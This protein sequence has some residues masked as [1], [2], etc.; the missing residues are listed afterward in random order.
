MT[1][2]DIEETTAKPFPRVQRAKGVHHTCGPH[3]PSATRT[4]SS[5]LSNERSAIEGHL[6]AWCRRSSG[7]APPEALVVV[8]DLR[9]DFGRRL[10]LYLF[11]R[12]ALDRRIRRALTG[13]GLPSL[14]VPVAIDHGV[15]LL[16]LVAPEWIPWLDE[17]PPLSVAILAVDADDVPRLAFGS[18]RDG[19]L[20]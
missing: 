12:V 9:G 3:R 15:A 19:R 2:D 6:A 14:S 13:G 7:F 17:R 18:L 1:L 11:D 20:H 4:H 5:L 10:G 16:E 8:T